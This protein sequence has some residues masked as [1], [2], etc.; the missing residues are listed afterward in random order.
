MH[1]NR[2]NMKL[3]KNSHKALGRDH[4]DHR[5]VHVMPHPPLH[6]WARPCDRSL[7]PLYLPTLY[8]NHCTLLQIYT[9]GDCVALLPHQLRVPPPLTPM[10]ALRP[11]SPSVTPAPTGLNIPGSGHQLWHWNPTV[12]H[13]RR[14]IP[15]LP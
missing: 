10:H 1:P 11:P 15:P 13:Q 4:P 8:Y 14:D 2:V 9:C 3:P 6:I 12:G 7:Q 5:V